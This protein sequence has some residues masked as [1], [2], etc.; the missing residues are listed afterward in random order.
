[1]D[2]EN[3]IKNL[4]IRV[5]KEIKRKMVNKSYYKGFN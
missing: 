3:Y 2:A 4:S 5:V 1:M